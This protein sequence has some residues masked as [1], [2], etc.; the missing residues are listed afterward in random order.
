MGVE[1]AHRSTPWSS[2]SVTQWFQNVSVGTL[3][4][5]NTC[6]HSLKDTSPPYKYAYLQ[7]Q[8]LK[9]LPAENHET[10]QSRRVILSRTVHE[11]QGAQISFYWQVGKEKLRRGSS[12]VNL[13]WLHSW[14]GFFFFFSRTLD[15][16]NMSMVKP[17]SEKKRKR[18][19]EKASLEPSEVNLGVLSP[20]S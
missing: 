14:L 13:K 19:K 18:G 17:R 20:S 10:Q 9:M 15:F 16:G 6:S 2:N 12:C 3:E 1:Q 11:V 4:I 5:S 7:P 8:F